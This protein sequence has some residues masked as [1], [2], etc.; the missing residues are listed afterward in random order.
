MDLVEDF[1]LGVGNP[2]GNAM[3]EFC[4]ENDLVVSNTW[5]QL[6]KRRLYTWT[7]PLHL[8]SD[9]NIR[10]QVDYILVTKRF[11]NIVKRVTTYL[12][13]DIGSDHEALIANVQMRFKKIVR[14]TMPRRIDLSKLQDK[15]LREEV[16]Q[17][18][19]RR[20]REVNTDN[21]METHWNQIKESINIT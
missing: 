10:N 14:S 9:R 6:P 12:G 21:D 4:Q 5:F 13:A 11:R 17:D 15:E 19:N 18:I 1:G 2:R 7:S 20:I 3:F 8:A 16:A